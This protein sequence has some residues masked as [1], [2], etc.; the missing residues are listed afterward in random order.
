MNPYQIDFGTVSPLSFTLAKPA[1]ASTAPP[2]ERQPPVKTRVDKTTAKRLQAAR[3]VFSDVEM[4]MKG[5]A[6]DLELDG[7]FDKCSLLQIFI[8]KFNSPV[9]EHANV[10][11]VAFQEKRQSPMWLIGL[12]ESADALTFW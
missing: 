3:D 5:E 7:F 6:L 12:G 10:N 2:V 8:E 4:P 11:P 1:E 9:F